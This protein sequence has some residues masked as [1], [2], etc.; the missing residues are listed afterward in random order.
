MAMKKLMLTAMA[1]VATSVLQAQTPKPVWELGEKPLDPALTKGKAEL[2]DGVVKL[3]GTN[4]FAVPAAVLG[5]QNDYTVEFVLKRPLKFQENLS[6]DS[7]WLVSNFDAGKGTGFEL[8]YNPSWSAILCVNGNTIAGGGLNLKIFDNPKENGVEATKITFVVKDKGLMLFRNGLLLLATEAVKPSALP[9]TFGEVAKAP[10][11]PYELSGLKIYDTAVFPTGFDAGAERMRIYSGDHYFIQRVEV[12]DPALPR[13]LVV[14]DSISMG[15]RGFITKHFQGKAYVDYW[16]GGGW[17]GD[18]A[19]K[20][21]NSDAKRSWTGVLSNGP[22]DVVSWNAMTLHMWNGMPGRADEATFPELMEEMTAFVQQSAPNTKLIW[23]RCTPWRTTPDIGRPEIDPSHND[24][25]VRLNKVVD[26]IMEKHGIPEVDLYSLCEKRFGTL[27]DG[28]K[29][30]LHWNEKVSQEMADLI[31][32][33]LEKA[34]ATKREGK[35]K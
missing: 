34:L 30:A 19:A 3:D 31:I 13:I 20:G 33:E 29:D 22:Y 11:S 8:R 32:P 15:Y 14:G 4:S 12:K 7:L 28:Y 23:V 2:A 25:I 18:D 10:V 35:G 6:L 24:H 1:C 21:P 16:T 17:I 26:G 5:A 27:P 9:L